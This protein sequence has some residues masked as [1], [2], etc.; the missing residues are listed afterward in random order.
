VALPAPL[1]AHGSRLGEEDECPC[2]TVDRLRAPPPPSP[3]DM[4]TVMMATH[5]GA[6][7]LPLVLE[8]Y[9]VLEPPEGGWSVVIV[10]NGSTDATKDI[11]NAF[12]RRLPLTYVYEPRPGKNQALNAALPAAIGDLIVFT[13][14]DAVPRP[15]W[16]R[17]LRATADTQT[18]FHMFGGRIVPRWRAA[19]AVDSS[20]RAPVGRL[21]DQPPSP[22]RSSRPAVGVRRQHG[23]EE[24]DLRSRIPL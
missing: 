2:R 14:D 8:A 9:V 12:A 19:R 22:T 13:D 1:F 7:T 3:N 23:R 6:R 5:N 10:D 15:D 16:L 20:S 11:I 4:L 18:D 21:R 17:R 24:G